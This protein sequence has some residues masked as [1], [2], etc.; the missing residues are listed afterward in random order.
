MAYSNA[1]QYHLMSQCRCKKQTGSWRQQSR[2]NRHN[3]KKTWPLCACI[4]AET[5]RFM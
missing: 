2:T 5:E 4:S 3:F 1:L